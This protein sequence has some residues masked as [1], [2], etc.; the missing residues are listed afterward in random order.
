MDKKPFFS[1]ERVEIL[2]ALLIALVTLA[3]A[4]FVWRTNVLGSTAGDLIHSGLIDAIK[5]QASSNE[6]WRKVYE[7]ASY[8]R[9]FSVYLAGVEAMESSGDANLLSQAKNLRQYLLPNLQ[10]ISNPLGTDAKY[11]LPNGTYD[12]QKRFADLESENTELASLNPQH[13]IDMAN[14][15]FSQQRWE[16]IGLI[17]LAIS[18]FW[19]S[20][21]ELSRKWMRPVTIAMGLGLFLLGISWELVLEAIFAVSRSSLL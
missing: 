12:L 8:A 9:D 13:S 18:L 5:T 7:E 21:A 15:Y 10:L 20:L 14:A 1:P 19:L 3:T 17:L 4:I 16:S 6:D 2:L 11:H